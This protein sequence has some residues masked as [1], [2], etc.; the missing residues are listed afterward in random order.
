MMWKWTV[1]VVFEAGQCT[2]WELLGL[3]VSETQDCA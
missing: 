2:K 1:E 3:V